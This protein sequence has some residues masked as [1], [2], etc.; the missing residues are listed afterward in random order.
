MPRKVCILK[1]FFFFFC[2]FGNEARNTFLCNK[3]SEITHERAIDIQIHAFPQ[4]GISLW[5]PFSDNK[6]LIS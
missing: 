4:M 2:L 1:V 3:E 5:L 6:N